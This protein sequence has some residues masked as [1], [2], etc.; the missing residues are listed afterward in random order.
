VGY[1]VDFFLPLEF[2]PWFVWFIFVML[3]FC[4]FFWCWCLIGLVT[5]MLLSRA[6]F[7]VLFFEEDFGLPNRLDDSK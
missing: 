7:S 5:A 1:R 6:R 3:L 4:L 2:P